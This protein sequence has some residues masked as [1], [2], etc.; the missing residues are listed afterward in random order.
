MEQLWPMLKLFLYSGPALP[1]HL[2]GALKKEAGYFY[3]TLSNFGI[4]VWE[5]P[6]K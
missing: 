3:L 5:Y 4:W 6:S 2:D 1:A